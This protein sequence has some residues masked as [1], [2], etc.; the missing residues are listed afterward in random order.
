M[1]S[2]SLGF[3]LPSFQG[4]PNTMVMDSER[5]SCVEMGVEVEPV[6]VL[7]ETEDGGH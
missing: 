4:A 3:C 2:S 7:R 1:L 6:F 5:R